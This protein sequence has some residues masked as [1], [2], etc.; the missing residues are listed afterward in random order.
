MKSIIVTILGQNYQRQNWS[1]DFNDA[2]F[3]TFFQTLTVE[4]G[5]LGNDLIL[6]KIW[7]GP[8]VGSLL[9][10]KPL[11]RILLFARFVITVGVAVN[12]LV[13]LTRYNPFYIHF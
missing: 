2:A 13:V 7:P 5:Q 3:L 6:W 4:L 9:L 10:L 1:F 12:L 8:S 11:S